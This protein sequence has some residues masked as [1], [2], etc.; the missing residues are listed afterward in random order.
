M[1][2]IGYF[3]RGVPDSVS[4]IQFGLEHILVLLLSI[5]I[6]YIIIKINKENRRLEVFIGTVLLIQQATLYAWYIYN[7]YN[8]LK[9]GLPLYH[10]RIA[11]LFLS[12]GLILNKEKLVKIGGYWGIL[13]GIFA[14]AVPGPDP[15]VFPHITIASYF[16]G[17]LFLLWGSIYVLSVKKI[18]MSKNDF[19]TLLKF[20]NI[21]CISMYVFNYI[22]GSNYGYMNTSPI[23]FGRE[24][25]Q[26]TYGIIILLL[27]NLVISAIYIILNN[28]LN[29]SLENLKNRNL[30]TGL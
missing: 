1:D 2:N 28:K 18:G 22:V 16:I 13:G 8:I 30:N 20:T 9:Q 21:Y 19:K 25:N 4:F 5:L 14:L 17:H 12:I 26:L 15:F 7:N 10:C 27:S 6:S 3:F 29:L 24:L 23:A 11:I